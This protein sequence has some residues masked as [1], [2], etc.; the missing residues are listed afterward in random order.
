LAEK[1]DSISTK[2]MMKLPLDLAEMPFPEWG[3]MSFLAFYLTA[4]IVL[5]FWC[6]SR[7]K[8]SLRRFDHPDHHAA[9]VDP[10]EAAFLSAGPGRVVLL[11]VTRLLHQGYARWKPGLLDARLQAQAAVFPASLSAAE[12]A[13]MKKISDAGAKGLS[14]RDAPRAVFPAMRGIEVGLAS[15]GLRPTREERGSARLLS[16]MPLVVLGFTGLVMVF[17][18]FGSHLELLFQVAMLAATV[19][20]IAVIVSSV[21]RLT[22]SGIRLLMK[23]SARNAVERSRSTPDAGGLDVLSYSVALLGPVALIRVPMFAPI[24]GDLRKLHY[25]SA[26]ARNRSGCGGAACGTGCSSNWSDS[27]CGSSCGGGGSGCGGGGCGGGD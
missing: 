20:A 8:H 27:G 4:L 22:D 17:I 23:L 13:L 7:A 21:P 26:A 5:I 12:Q 3:G 1:H 11:A 25:R 18:G 9:E 16:V 14:A 2:A 24:Y 15:K 10:Y 6:A 19:I